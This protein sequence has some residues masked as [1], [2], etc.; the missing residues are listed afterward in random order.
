MPAL[1]LVL[2]LALVVVLCAAAEVY[3]KGSSSISVTT[4][5]NVEVDSNHDGLAL[6]WA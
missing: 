2:V 3:E 4:I 6:V 1:A 5:S